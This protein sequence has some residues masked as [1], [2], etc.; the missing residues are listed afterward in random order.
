MFLKPEPLEG[1]GKQKRGTRE[2]TTLS[3]V[4]MIATSD[5]PVFR[6]TEK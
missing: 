5:G 2:I 3:W 4:L 6:K 1:K